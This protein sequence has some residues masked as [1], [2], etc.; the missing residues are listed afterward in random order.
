MPRELTSNPAVL[1]VQASSVSWSG[2]RDRCMFMLDGK[3]LFAH[4]LERARKLF[5]QTPIRVVA[6]EFDRGGLDRIAAAIEGCQVSYGYDD[7]PLKR[8]IEATRDLADDALILRI[9]GLHCFFQEGIV[10][11]LLDAA[12]AEDLDI[13]K[14]PDDFP[15]TLTGEVWRVGAL[16]HLDAMLSKWPAERAA[17]HYVQPKFIA[18]RKE[19]DLRGRIVAP[20]AVA[21]S[22][23]TTAR[24]ALA[25]A[26]EGDYTE[27]TGKS[28]AVGDQ[29][30][31]HY[32]LAKR[33]LKPGD[34]VLD[35]ASGKGF[36]GNILAAVAS[37]VICADID[38]TKLEEGRKLFQRDNLVFAR[39]DVMNMS[40]ADAAFDVVVSMETI[41]HVDD[42]D[43]YLAEIRRVLKPGGRAILSTPQNCI[44]RIPL[45]P[46]HVQEFSLGDLRSYCG[47]HFEI[48]K[49]IGIKAGIIYFE[50]DPVGA[51][52]M[53]FLRKS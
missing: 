11:A 34:R 26:F 25:R 44:G 21:D 1:L 29:I 24:A 38:E 28:I 12:A 5:S 4:T 48:E 35:I 33:R 42:V 50:D 45:T 52:T 19:S 20:P 43:G 16:R 30:S 9:D 47:R 37:F 51:N 36:G 31:F 18:M 2:G 46:I 3:P 39:E 32:V 53:I 8:M 13:A 7:K 15:P 40:F 23:L 17:P 41:E 14:S 27:V 10:R 22:V 49:V 6:P